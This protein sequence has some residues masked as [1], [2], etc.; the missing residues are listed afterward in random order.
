MLQIVGEYRQ[1]E[2]IRVSKLTIDD[3]DGPTQY[4][5]S[6]KT[7][8]DSWNWPL[9]D[10]IRVG[11]RN[12]EY[13]V[14]EGG[15]RVREAKRF[16]IS[17][18]PAFVFQSEGVRAEADEFLLVARCRK[19][20]SAYDK[21]KAAVAAGE[22]RASAVAEA[23]SRHGITLVCGSNRQWPQLAVVTALYR[24]SVESLDSSLDIICDLWAGDGD[25]LREPI[26]AGMAHFI[27][28][29]EKIDLSK[30]REKLRLL[31]PQ[32]IIQRQS[33]L[34]SR[35]NKLTQYAKVFYDIYNSRKRNTQD[36][37]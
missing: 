1:P 30:L 10:P 28:Q 35:T 20:L 23:L 36:Q 9:Y 33:G 16:G 8:F 14:V 22:P 15:R 18:L 31:S 6:V 12:D 21:H 4:Q 5:R 32:S 11:C 27:G 24:V 29:T 26:V 17:E 2:L 37:K 3:G 34:P 13:H 25:A 7:N 19:R